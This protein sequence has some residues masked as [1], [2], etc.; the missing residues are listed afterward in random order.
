MKRAT[1][2]GSCVASLEHVERKEAGGA[3]E[4]AE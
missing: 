1:S 4:E 2:V 3:K